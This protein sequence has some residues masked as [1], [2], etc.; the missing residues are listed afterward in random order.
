MT[1]QLKKSRKER[2][3][4]E[5][6]PLPEI[7]VIA[8]VVHRSCVPLTFPN[9]LICLFLCEGGVVMTRDGMTAISRIDDWFPIVHETL[10][11]TKQPPRCNLMCTSGRI[12]YGSQRRLMVS[13]GL[14]AD[15]RVCQGRTSGKVRATCLCSLCL[16]LDASFL[17]FCCFV[18]FRC[19]R[20]LLFMTTIGQ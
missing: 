18:L 9:R 5:V 3:A 14:I 2:K 17:D 20:R 15:H 10:D 11:L 6:W 8:Y 7:N 12:S 1:K 16:L 19:C 13:F 4:C